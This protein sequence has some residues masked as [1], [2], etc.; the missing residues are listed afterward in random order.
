MQVYVQ[1]IGGDDMK[2]CIAVIVAR[3]AVEIGDLY[4]WRQANTKYINLY[5][6][7]KNITSYPH[8]ISRNAEIQRISA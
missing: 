3:N 6:N 4:S 8:D 1:S 7:S 2:Q 5:I